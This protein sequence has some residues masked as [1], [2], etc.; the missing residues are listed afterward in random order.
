MKNLRIISFFTFVLML[1]SFANLAAQTPTTATASNNT[2][3]Q[4]QTSGE[5]EMCKKT[6][7]SEVG[8]MTGVKK[9]T[10]DVETKVLT[11]EYNSK[12]TN[13]DK[14]RK[15]IAAIGYDADDVKANNRARKELP[16]CCK[17]GGK[18]SMPK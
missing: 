6:I 2:S 3:V 7:E 10:L 4:I 9:A 12:K 15:A 18:D 11:V 16:G 14:V 17:P 1:I 8:K 5:C 13:P